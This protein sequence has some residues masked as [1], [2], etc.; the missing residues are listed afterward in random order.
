MGASSMNS[1]CTKTV[2]WGRGARRGLD[3]VF[4]ERH[5]ESLK[6]Y[7]WLEKCEEW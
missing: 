5:C 2:H 3:W 6:K 7:F 1:Q 4:G